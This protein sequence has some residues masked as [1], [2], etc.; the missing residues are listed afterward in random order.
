MHGFYPYI[1]TLM[2][3]S[4]NMSFTEIRVQSDKITDFSNYFPNFWHCKIN[5]SYATALNWYD[6]FNLIP[7]ITHLE[8]VSSSS[9]LDLNT[10]YK[11]LS[12]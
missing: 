8:P 12:N 4:L 7:A 2:K 5:V 10:S 9:L 6:D 11:N 3:P 1:F